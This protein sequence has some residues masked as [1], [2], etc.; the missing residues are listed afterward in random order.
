[1]TK[2]MC[3]I[4]KGAIQPADKYAAEKLR[5]R[6]FKVGDI[7]A[8]EVTRPRNPGFHRL[9]HHI[10]QLMVDNIDDFALCAAHGALKRM[11]LEAGI[12]CEEMMIRMPGIGAVVHRTAK[13]LSYES[14][15]QEEFHNVV[16]AF[17]RHI[18]KQYWPQ[19]SE[20]KILEMAKAFVD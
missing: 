18:S 19:L 13:S 20:D 4:V 14:M 16:Q 10:G 17:C 7:V 9:A 8:V 15:G 3:R 6:N 11:Q 2:I 12:A 5:A 1:M